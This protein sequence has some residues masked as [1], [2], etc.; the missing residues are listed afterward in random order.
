ML[1]YLVPLFVDCL[2]V[3][4]KLLAKLLLLVKVLLIHDKLI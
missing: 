3:L 1:P 4:A 2:R